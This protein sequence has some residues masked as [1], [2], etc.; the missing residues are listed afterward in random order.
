[1]NQQRYTGFQSIGSNNFI[2][3]FATIYR[4]TR[5]TSIS[6]TYSHS[7]FLYQH[8]GGMSRVDS[9]FA[10]LGHNFSSRWQVNASAGLTRA[11]SAGTVIL[12]VFLQ[13]NGVIFPVYI[14]TPYN[15]VRLLPYYQ[16][17]VT[18]IMQHSNISLSGG[19]SVGPG[20]GFYLASKTISANGLYV[21]NLRRSKLSIGAYFNRLAS[22]A[23][24]VD[25][26]ATSIGFDGAYSYNIM[27]HVG[28]SLQ[29]DYFKYSNLGPLN[30]PSDNRVTFGVYFTSKDIPLGWH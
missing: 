23:T 19:E 2:G 14:K 10:T 18:R 16:L 30:V 17:T 15:E 9:G 5:K 7:N 3:S 11:T 22:V 25:A 4:L 27:R 12:P 20:N 6:G 21:Y 29:Y 28:L 1:M 24:A 26:R 8:D 13:V